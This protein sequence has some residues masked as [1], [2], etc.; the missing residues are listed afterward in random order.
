MDNSFIYCIFAES[1]Y[2]LELFFKHKI[3][4]FFHKTTANDALPKCVA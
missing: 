4:N 2:F 3:T 1:S